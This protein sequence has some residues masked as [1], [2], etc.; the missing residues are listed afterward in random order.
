MKKFSSILVCF[1]LMLVVLLGGCSKA[2]NA[3]LLDIRQ[4]YSDISSNFDGLFVGD[5]FNP[6]YCD[7]MLNATKSAETGKFYYL[8]SDNDEY[9][10]DNRNVYGLLFRSTNSTFMTCESTFKINAYNN[11]ANKQNKKN[12]YL[13]LESLQNNLNKLVSSKKNLEDCFVYGSK[14]YLLIAKDST[15]NEFLKVYLEDL[16]NCLNDFLIF[17]ENLDQILKNNIYKELGLYSQINLNELLY[18]SPV[19]EI[20]MLSNQE[21]I[22]SCNILISNYLLNYSYA[23][24]GDINENENLVNNLK[25]LVNLEI[26]FKKESVT[27][28]SKIETYKILRTLEDGLLKQKDLFNQKAKSESEIDKNF[29]SN[30]SINLLNYSSKLIEYLKSL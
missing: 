9:S 15:T 28:N 24:K 17:N 22:N 13:S 14:S 1:M 20:N 3:S 29:V 18:A 4:K 16:N 7:Q 12:M 2:D 19:T 5:A 10:F 27:E 6:S 11:L 30:Y 8:K 26:V 21:L 23:Q 25:S